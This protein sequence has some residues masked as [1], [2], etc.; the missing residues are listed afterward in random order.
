MRL[1]L[2]DV[3]RYDIPEIDNGHERIIAMIN[4]FGDCLHNNDFDAALR[5]VIHLIAVERK[6]AH[7]ENQL[8]AK[9]FYSQAATH[10]RYHDSLKGL[11]SDIMEALGNGERELSRA[12]HDQLCN[13]FIDD[14]LTADLPFKSLLQDR[15]LGR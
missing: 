13:A 2:N 14:L 10:N 7:F 15:V 9:H 8:L 1:A 5:Q 6:H 4:E 11:L 12:L 3:F